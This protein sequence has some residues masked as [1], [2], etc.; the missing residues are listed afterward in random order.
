MRYIRERQKKN[1]MSF[2]IP[3]IRIVEKTESEFDGEKIDC[4]VN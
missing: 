3:E 1:L 2:G 4:E